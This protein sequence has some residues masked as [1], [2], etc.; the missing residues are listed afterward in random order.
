MTLPL[1][2]TFL[3]IDRTK[4]SNAMTHLKALPKKNSPRITL[5]YVGNVFGEWDNCIWF[6]AET[7]DHAMNFVQ[8]KIAKIPGVVQ[9]YTLPTTPVKRFYKPLK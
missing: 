1:Y 8:R 9:T 5:Y 2:W 4:T 6:E 3:R 7:H